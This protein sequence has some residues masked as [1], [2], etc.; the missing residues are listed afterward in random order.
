V[1]APVVAVREVVVTRAGRTILDVPAL[2]VHDGE[3]LAII[4]PNGAGK[5][6]LLRVLALLEPPGRGAVTVRGAAATTPA[7]RL[8]LRRRMAS[9][10]QSPLLC[11]GTVAENAALALRFRGVGRAEAE[12]R[13]RPWLERLEVADL[14]A[15]P[16]RT[17]SG[18]EAQRVS[19]ARALAAGPEVLFLDEPFAALDPPTREALLDDFARLMAETQTTAVFVT[20]ERGEALRLG[21]RVAV[22]LDGRLAQVGPPAA[23][24]GAPADE[25]VA[26]FVGVENLLRGRVLR[27][28]DGVVEVAIGR[29]VVAA[30]GRAEVGETALIGVRP[31]AVVLEEAAA[32][33]RTSARNRLAGTVVAVTTQGALARVVVDCGVPLTAVV[34][35]PSIEAVGLAPGAPVVA[36]FKASAAHLV[37]PGR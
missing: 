25:A 5:S 8:A 31:E 13:A 23:V 34:T 29:H 20:H 1:S 24:F 22:L 2:E 18:G 28:A 33:P 19:L 27:A 12:R 3:V 16:A 9:V 30:V 35:G 10:F 6:T 4:G 36:S 32:A 14:A 26:R 17:L 21:D 7:A 11:D 37:R 15:R